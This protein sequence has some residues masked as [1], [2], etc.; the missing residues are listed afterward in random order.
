MGSPGA[1][2]VI[3]T[4]TRAKVLVFMVFLLG[5][6]TGALITNV[7]ESRLNSDN[8]SAARRSQREVNR[9]YD[10]LELTAEQR[11]Q[12]QRITEASRPDFEKLFE[13]NRKLL[14][15][16]QRK[17]GEL[18][19]QTRTKIRA[20]LTEEQIKKYNAYNEKRRRRPPMPRQN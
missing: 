18:Q 1:D 6:L 2:A 15:P 10:L 5:A 4:T 19:E 9:L 20:I 12:F 16:N 14:E 8:D 7:Y 11:Q 13:E 3:A 17:Y